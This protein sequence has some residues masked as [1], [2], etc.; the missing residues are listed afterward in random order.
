MKHQ[1][2][3]LTK[4]A[5]GSYKTK[6]AR[7]GIMNRFMTYLKQ[8]NIQIK[9]V[10]QIKVKHIE[11]YIDYRSHQNINKRTLQNEMSAIRQTLKQAGRDKLIASERLSNKAL[12]INHASRDGAKEPLPDTI[13]NKVLHT[14]MQKNQGLV[15]TIQ[16][17]RI[18]GLRGEEAVQSAQSLQT[19]QKLLNQGKTSL[20]VIF[21]TKG[22]RPRETTIINLAETKQAVSFAIQVA[23]HQNGKLI[24]KPSLKQAMT[25]WRNETSKLG[26]R[27]KYAPHSLRYAYAKDTIAYYQDQGL[28]KEEALA[29]VST[30]LGHGDGR[31]RYIKQVYGKS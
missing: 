18:L 1:I 14:A 8:S 29:K 9:D 4:A 24:D 7:E 16:L 13:Y 28:S 23:N 26:L 5:A 22:G 6:Y 19:W 12:A 27:G 21:G 15:A 2:K 11:K 30:D 3:Q 31:G 20:P 10:S 25:Y 17:D